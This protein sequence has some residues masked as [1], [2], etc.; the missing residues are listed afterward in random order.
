M[1]FNSGTVQASC[2]DYLHGH[3]EPMGGHA[4][5]NSD[6]SDPILG[7]RSMPLG[8]PVCSGPHCQRDQQAPAAPSKAIQVPTFNDA[9]LEAISTLAVVD[10]VGFVAP[11]DADHASGSVGRIFRP[12]RAA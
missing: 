4:A 10:D 1:S 5:M 9:I 3:G 7:H 2:G 11:S 12:P 8:R 6:G